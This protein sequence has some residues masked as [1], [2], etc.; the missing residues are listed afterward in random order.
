MEEPARHLYNAHLHICG[1]ARAIKDLVG[2]TIDSKRYNIDYVYRFQSH[3]SEK[4]TNKT[5]IMISPRRKWRWG[6]AQTPP[7]RWP[8][9][10]RW[11]TGGR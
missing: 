10:G 4:L 9:V 5:V 6:L 11:L 3:S 2:T 7:A 8:R 1:N